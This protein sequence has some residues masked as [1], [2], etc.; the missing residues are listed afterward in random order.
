[1]TN[2]FVTDWKSEERLAAFFCLFFFLEVPFTSASPERAVVFLLT[3]PFL[4]RTRQPL[5]TPHPT[6]LCPTT[7][8]CYIFLFIGHT[9]MVLKDFPSSWRL[10]TRTPTHHS[11]TLLLYLHAYIPEA[12]FCFCFQSPSLKLQALEADLGPLPSSGDP[13]SQENP[14]AQQQ[15]LSAEKQSLFLTHRLPLH[16]PPS[17]PAQ[18]QQ[19]VD[20]SQLGKKTALNFWYAEMIIFKFLSF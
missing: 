17:P 11:E 3:H 6:T 1:M 9:E 7:L 8:Q 2:A 18:E 16:S 15:P 5:I 20:S 10:S 14:P 4:R 19:I 12:M 13:Q